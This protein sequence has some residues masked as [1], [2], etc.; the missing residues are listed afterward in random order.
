MKTYEITQVDLVET[1][2]AVVR[3][4][5]S[6]AQMGPWLSQAFGAVDAYVAGRGVGPVGMPFGRYHPVG[7][8]RFAVEAG[9]PVAHEVAGAGQ[10]VGS[11]LP[12]GPAVQTWHVGPYEALAAAYEALE[13]WLR[14]HGG[15]A[16]GDAWEVYHS[17]PAAEPDPAGWRTEVIQPFR[18]AG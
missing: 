2:V 8:D 12:G 10:V 18:F 11:R 14:E 5:L 4:T 16:V 7:G 1:P 6:V 15:T 9:F 17:D 13:G 3:A